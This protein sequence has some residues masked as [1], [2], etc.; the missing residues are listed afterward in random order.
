MDWS[1]D[2]KEI[3]VAHSNNLVVLW[4]EDSKQPRLF[5]AQDGYAYDLTY[6]PNGEHLATAGDA[7]TI[8]S[9][10]DGEKLGEMKRD[11]GGRAIRLAWIKAG[12]EL[13]ALYDDNRVACWHISTVFLVKD[14]FS[15]HVR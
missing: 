7:L 2:G 5:I 11:D 14:S 8:W 12:E 9:P 3:A 10:E 13:L 6:S 4:D 15:R 1:P